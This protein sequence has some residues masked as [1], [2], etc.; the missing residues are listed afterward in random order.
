[1]AGV[2]VDAAVGGAPLA[3]TGEV[4]VRGA[5][6][7]ASAVRHGIARTEREIEDDSLEQV[8]VDDDVRALGRCI[9]DE[10]DG[11]AEP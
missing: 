9:D 11:R 7:D 4:D 6:R 1:M 5:D 8:R 2:E 10:V 3:A